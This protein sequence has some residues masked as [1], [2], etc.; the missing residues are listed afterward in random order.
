MITDIL[1]REYASPALR[2][3]AVV[4]AARE[5]R[6]PLRRYRVAACNLDDPAKMNSVRGV[7]N[8]CSGPALIGEGLI[9]RPADNGKIVIFLC[10]D[11]WEIAD[12]CLES[13]NPRSGDW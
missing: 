7:C 13:L 9:D 4:L 5:D 1:N 10:N 8:G 2:I 6:T 11:C 12:R 3:R